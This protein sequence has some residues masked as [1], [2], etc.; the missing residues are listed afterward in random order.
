MERSAVVFLF[1]S[2]ACIGRIYAYP[3]AAQINQQDLCVDIMF[4]LD[5]SEVLYPSE[6]FHGEWDHAWNEMK[7]YIISMVDKYPIGQQHT[8]FAVIGFSTI[9][10]PQLRFEESTNAED[11]KTKIR[12]I[13]VLCK[14]PAL[15]ARNTSDGYE[16]AYAEFLSSSRNNVPKYAIFVTVY[17]AD[18]ATEDQVLV[19]ASK[20]R[21]LN[22]YLYMVPMIDF[23]YDGVF[24]KEVA[25]THAR[26]GD[27]R[28]VV[29]ELNNY[30]RLQNSSLTDLVQTRTRSESQCGKERRVA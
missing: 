28:S 26:F 11:L 1:F 22:V 24:R 14:N 7:D 15:S 30:D 10:V 8:R 29:L 13:E 20:L 16:K 2:W 3:T 5:E 4:I 6:E 9:G 27:Q 19:S 23:K 21:D 17:A 18:K 12:N 25:D